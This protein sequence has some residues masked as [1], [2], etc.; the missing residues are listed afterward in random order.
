MLYGDTKRTL[1]K[2]RECLEDLFSGKFVKIISTFGRVKR[3]FVQILHWGK[4][5]YQTH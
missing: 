2:Y 5:K 3:G 1:D 4:M